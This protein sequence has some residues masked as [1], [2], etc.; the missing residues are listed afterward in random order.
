MDKSLIAAVSA[1]LGALCSHLLT[2]FAARRSR[3][4][5]V[6]SDEQFSKQE[7]PA[8]GLGLSLRWQSFELDNFRITR[9]RVMNDS[10]RDFTHVPVRVWSGMDRVIL[11]DSV[12]HLGALDDITYRPEYL[13]KLRPDANGLLSEEQR[14]LFNTCREFVVPVWNRFSEIGITCLTSVAAGR[15]EGGVW[16][17]VNHPGIRLEDRAE[18]RGP[19]KV[20]NV[21]PSQIWKLSLVVALLSI[22]LPV[23]LLDSP[24]AVA[25]VVG[26]A[27]S[28]SGHVAAVLHRTRLR[29]RRWLTD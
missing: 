16:L 8:V 21:D 27:V 22:V 28:V 19:Q 25:V 10:S 17:E 1:S 24:V 29:L 11:Q 5:A 13:E 15:N 6:R 12:S 18:F 20:L 23:L 9:F 7:N 26:V 14:R 2:K 3:F 4:V